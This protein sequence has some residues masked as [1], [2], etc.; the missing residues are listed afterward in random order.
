MTRD[1]RVGEALVIWLSAVF[2]EVPFADVSGGVT[3]FFEDF[4]PGDAEEWEGVD[5]FL[6]VD[7]KTGD[8]IA[9]RDSA[10]EDAVAGWEAAWVGGV[11]VVKGHAIFGEGVHAGG[12]VNF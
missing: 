4:S 8:A 7:F 9:T 5:V 2:S 6:F 10:A 3:G 12:V 1:A 11:G